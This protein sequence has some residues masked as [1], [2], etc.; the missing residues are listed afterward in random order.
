[1]SGPANVLDF[2]SA[3]IAHDDNYFYF[4]YSNHA[5]DAVQISWGMSVQIDTD[6][7][8][9]TGF[10]GFGNELPIGVDYMI[11][12]QTLHRYTGSGND[13]SWAPGEL[14]P[15]VTNGAEFEMQVPREALG[16]PAA[17][18]LFFYA[19]NTAVNGDALDFYPDAAADINAA[20]EDRSFAY[21]AG[22][23]PV[24][25]VIV[26]PPAP[27]EPA[28]VLYNPVTSLSVDGE[29][30]DWGQLASF[31]GDPNDA[32]GEGNVI[33]WRE[34]WLAHSD[35]NFY[36]G[37]I[38][39]EAAQLS[40]GNGIMIDTDQDRTTGFTGFG[41]ELPIGVDY[42]LEADTIHRYTGAGTD[43]VWADGGAIAPVFAGNN[44]ELSVPRASLGNPVAMDLFFIG[45]N[46]ATGGTVIDYYP[47]AV[48]N[49]SARAADRSFSYSTVEP[50]TPVDPPAPSI[51]IAL[52]GNLQEWEQ[53]QQL[54]G[55]DPQDM[56]APNAL[57][58]RR[59]VMANDGQYLYL[60]YQGYQPLTL[61]W[62]LGVYLD[63]DQDA[64]TGFRGFANELA[65]GADF[66]LEGTELLEYTGA[67]QNEWSWGPEQTVELIV[68]GDSAEGRI[69]LSML[70]VTAGVD[71][72]L[73]G[74]NSAFGG[75]A[76]DFHPDTGL[77]S[78]T[79]EQ[80]STPSN[81]EP[82][83]Q[84]A[85]GGSGGGAF[86]SLWLMLVA[87][88]A[89]L[90]RRYRYLQGLKMKSRLLTTGA[91]GASLLLSACGGGN[92]G[93]TIQSGAPS[94]PSNQ[95]SFPDSTDQTANANPS[96]ASALARLSLDGTQV[97]PAVPTRARGAVSLNLNTVS[98][99]L[100]GTLE[101]SVA[102]ASGATL[103]IGSVGQNGAVIVT[104]EATATNEFQVPSGTMLNEQQIAVY[105]SGGMYVSV[106]SSDWPNGEIRAQL[107]TDPIDITVQPNLDDIQA[108]VFTPICSGCHTGGGSSLPGIMDLTTADGSY[109]SLIN[110]LSLQEPDKDRVSANDADNSY[111]INKLEG[112]QLTGS[113]MPFRGTPLDTD[114]VDAIRQWIDQG[115]FR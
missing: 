5:P 100:S 54:G 95:P 70:G 47:D 4:R 88:F 79:L 108:K 43:W 30:A 37:W 58:W 97:V 19:N 40:W 98:G 56:V 85:H 62:G 102:A 6:A 57:D 68:A 50:Q 65:V 7:N 72:V 84:A 18:R 89:A 55:E 76:V 67:T 3:A 41:N 109:N 8:P 75:D 83:A 63:V 26:D 49:R 23:D 34:G 15:A 111:L 13:F 60:G 87:V 33:D 45:N 42:L 10:R 82:F 27:T 78:Y 31:G 80:T 113:Q 74:D 39:D 29:L 9:A 103:H 22:T 52:D 17:M 107:T 35:S 94:S 32:S 69:A 71:V 99:D 66:L 1:M 51:E 90:G 11:E 77:L 14:Q 93:A 16:N 25:P 44:V 12:G 105:Q 73:R 2:A 21:N 115:A 92:G 81:D 96:F 114:V 53:S 110:T 38:N 28:S 20:L 106:Q 64:S 104:L 86:G 101:H 36:I 24:I 91:L 61:G 59:L 48:S 46:N 112:T